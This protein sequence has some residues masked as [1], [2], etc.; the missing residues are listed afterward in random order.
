[1]AAPVALAVGPDCRIVIGS[2]HAAPLSTPEGKGILDRV[3]IE[4]FRRI[5]YHACIE[6]MP[7]ERSL[8]NADAGVTDGDLLRVAE[9]VLARAPDLAAVPEMIYPLASNGFTMRH[10]LQLRGSD[11]LQPLRVGYV[12]GWKR[13][14]ERVQA[15]EVLRA[16]GPDELFALLIENKAD[17]VIYERVTGLELVRQLKQPG[18]RVIDPPLVVVPTHMVL[19][20]RHQKLLE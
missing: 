4:A 20:R 15:A 18:I 10:D 17:V 14:E 1:M 7:C 3:A 13:L 16:R 5:G 11:D 9:A 19:N 6:P 2:C 8:R 12:L